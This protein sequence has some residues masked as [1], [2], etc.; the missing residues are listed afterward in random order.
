MA[1]RMTKEGCVEMVGT[2]IAPMAGAQVSYWPS[3]RLSHQ[4]NP[5][6]LV[7]WVPG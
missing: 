6:A 3:T 2:V 5:F 1:A 7:V 4:T